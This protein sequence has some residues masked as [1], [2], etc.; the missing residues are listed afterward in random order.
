MWLLD[1]FLKKAITV[2]R[3][4]VTDH[5]GKVYEYGPGPEGMDRGPMHI[6]LTNRKAAASRSTFG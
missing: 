5:D 2:G 3:F 1:K 6:R 4:V